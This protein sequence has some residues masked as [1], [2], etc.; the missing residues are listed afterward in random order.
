MGVGG[1]RSRLS[2]GS[3]FLHG[4]VASLQYADGLSWF[5]TRVRGHQILRY[6][7]LGEMSRRFVAAVEKLAADQGIPLIEFE[8]GK[9]KEEIAAPLFERARLPDREGVVLIGSVQERLNVFS[10][11]N[12]QE[13]QS[14]KFGPARPKSSTSTSGTA[15]GAPPTSG[16]APTPPSPCASNGRDSPI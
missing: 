6:E 16:S 3:F 1:V 7:I 9:R 11:P 5:L 13:R 14:G 4:Y 8:R 10:P 2:K 12:K 15:T